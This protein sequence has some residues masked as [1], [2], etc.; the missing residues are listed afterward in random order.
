VV[1]CRKHADLKP[2]EEFEKDVYFAFE[3]SHE[4][5]LGEFGLCFQRLRD[6]L[7]V[8]QVSLSSNLG[9]LGDGKQNGRSDLP[10]NGD[11]VS[12]F[13]HLVGVEGR[14][15]EPHCALVGVLLGSLEG[16]G[17]VPIYLKYILSAHLML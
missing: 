13:D 15:V 16:V 11:I 12:N 1:G 9:N 5:R 10:Q 17:L 3:L 14:Q 4:G 7:V 8:H 2:A 6:I